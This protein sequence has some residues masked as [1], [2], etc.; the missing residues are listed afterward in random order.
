MADRYSNLD[1]FNRELEEFVRKTVPDEL[2]KLHRRVALEALRRIV[3]MTPV[4]TGRARGNWQTTID[5]SPETPL[6]EF[7]PSGEATILEGM[8]RLEA[9]GFG[10]I[11]FLTNN[12]PY[13]LRLEHGHSR[14]APQGMVEVTFAELREMFAQPVE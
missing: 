3:L 1:E 4:D 9:L 2:V 5:V 14:Q 8:S 13:I 10:S 6:E 7:D 12:L 11:V